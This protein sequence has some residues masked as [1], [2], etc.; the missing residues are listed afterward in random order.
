MYR[1]I[2]DGA[3]T[4]ATGRFEPRLLAREADGSAS[5]SIGLAISL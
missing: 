2:A 3:A 4:L 5:G 1:D